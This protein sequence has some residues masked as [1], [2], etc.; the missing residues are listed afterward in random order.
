MCIC[1]CI[2]RY[3]IFAVKAKHACLF[4][5]SIIKLSFSWWNFG[6]TKAIPFAYFFKKNCVK[7]LFCFFLFSTRNV[8]FFFRIFSRCDEID[9]EA[10]EICKQFGT[11]LFLYVQIGSSFFMVL[12]HSSESGPHKVNGKC[13]KCASSKYL[14]K[15]ECFCQQIEMYI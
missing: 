5:S 2:Q 15:L 7:N 4:I 12:I 8:I 10:N 11:F 13:S 14:K 9:N 6:V 3:V 1:Q